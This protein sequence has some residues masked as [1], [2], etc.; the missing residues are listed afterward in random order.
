MAWLLLAGHPA[1]VLVYT[2]N[3]APD[4]IHS[5]GE[6]RHWLIG[7][8]DGGVLVVVFTIRRPGNVYR[9]ISARPA[10][11]RERRRYEEARRVPL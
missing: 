1:S 3:A 8:G 2:E 9:L 7:M 4:V 6:E 10:S 5:V 11:R